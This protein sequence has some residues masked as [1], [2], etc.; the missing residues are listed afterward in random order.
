LGE[1]IPP[2]QLTMSNLKFMSNNT[3]RQTVQFPLIE[4]ILKLDITDQWNQV[5]IDA[6]QMY[7]FDFLEINPGMY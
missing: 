7:L 2:D 5:W 1:I 6:L 3:V 4:T